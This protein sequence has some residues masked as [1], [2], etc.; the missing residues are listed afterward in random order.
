MSAS[1][2]GSEMCIRDSCEATTSAAA[3]VSPACPELGGS[4]LGLT[5]AGSKTSASSAGAMAEDDLLEDIAVPAGVEGAAVLAVG[6]AAS[7]TA[8]LR[9]LAGTGSLVRSQY[10][11]LRRRACNSSFRAG[12]HFSTCSMPAFSSFRA[13]V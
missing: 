3:G 7:D 4:S 9:A 6:A 13:F 2:V 8:R 5:A 1:L 10:S 11:R 12:S